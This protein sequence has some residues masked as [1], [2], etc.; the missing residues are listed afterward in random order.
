MWE[1]LNSD[2]PNPFLD[3]LNLQAPYALELLDFWRAMIKRDRAY[4]S[5]LE[6]HYDEIRAEIGPTEEP[7][8]GSHLSSHDAQKSSFRPLTKRER[9]VR[10][11]L[12]A[13]A[14]RNKQTLCS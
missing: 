9:T 11:R 8:D 14:R 6:R 4:A 3:P 7:W 13:R 10:K 12:L 5:R 2:V 1:R